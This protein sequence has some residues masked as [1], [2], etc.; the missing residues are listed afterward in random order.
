ML[1]NN[2]YLVSNITVHHIYRRFLETGGYTRRRTGPQRKTNA[3]DDRFIILQRLR[4][5]HATAV[6]IRKSTWRSQSC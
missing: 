4:Q 1:P 5:R 3:Y 2:K 6:G